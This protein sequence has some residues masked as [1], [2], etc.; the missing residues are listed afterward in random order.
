LSANEA[1]TRIKIN[2][3]LIQSGWW[4]FDDENGKANI[5]LENNV[6]FTQ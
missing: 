2:N 6:T 5:S 3:L 4:F 1:K